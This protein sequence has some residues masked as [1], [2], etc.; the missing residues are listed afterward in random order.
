[1]ARIFNVIMFFNSR[2]SC[3]TDYI[4]M[5]QKLNFKCYKTYTTE[6]K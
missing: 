1:M 2:W 4:D 5:I 3:K 6:Y